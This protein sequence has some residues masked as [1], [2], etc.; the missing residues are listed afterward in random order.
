[1]YAKSYVLAPKNITENICVA[2]T[3][4]IKKVKGGRVS[5]RAL[6][7][8]SECWSLFHVPPPPWRYKYDLISVGVVRMTESKTYGT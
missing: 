6:K 3:Y 8:K 2:K 4:Y 1:M 5:G 7:K